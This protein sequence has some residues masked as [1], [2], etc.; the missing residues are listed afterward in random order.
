MPFG[1][2][3][4]FEMKSVARKQPWTAPGVVDVIEESVSFD[5]GELWV[6]PVCTLWISGIAMT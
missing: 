6:Y 4:V 3:P 5:L 2:M 1:I